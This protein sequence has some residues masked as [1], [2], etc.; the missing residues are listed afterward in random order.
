MY[1]RTQRGSE[2]FPEK[3]KLT[4]FSLDEINELN[5]PENLRKRATHVSQEQLR[6]QSFRKGLASNASPEE[7]GKLLAE[8]H[9]SS[10]QN[11][12]NSCIE[13][14]FLAEHLNQHDSVLG[15]RLTG[16]GFG[17]AVMAWTQSNFSK[18]DANE[19]VGLYNQE[20]GQEIDYHNFLPSDGARKENIL[21]VQPDSIQ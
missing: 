4:S 9:A 6:V 17:G 3:D 5:L 12:E 18:K 19:I 2:K 8:S 7:L 21:K 20:F 16:G 14:D 10:S 1:G 11:F 15:A 13:L